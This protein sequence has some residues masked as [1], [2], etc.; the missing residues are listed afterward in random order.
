MVECGGGGGPGGGEVE[1]G[2]YFQI[3]R[4]NNYIRHA[5]DL[6]LM[7]GALY[8]AQFS[9]CQCRI[10]DVEALYNS[11]YCVVMPQ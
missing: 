4:G 1:M 6:I 10:H 11:H 2:V 8:L 7:H 3:T 5:P 9:H